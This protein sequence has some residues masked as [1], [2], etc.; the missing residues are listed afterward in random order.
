MNHLH[1]PICRY[2]VTEV[3]GEENNEPTEN[4][5]LPA[6]SEATSLNF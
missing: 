5:L 3:A 6:F 2:I 4:A 1:F